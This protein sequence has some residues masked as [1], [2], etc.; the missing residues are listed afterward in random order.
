M[1]SGQIGETV[2]VERLQINFVSKILFEKKSFVLSA[3]NNLISL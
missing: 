3:G 2:K 1:G